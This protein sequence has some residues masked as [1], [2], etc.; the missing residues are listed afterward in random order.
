MCR[1]G[2]RRSNTL[3]SIF[4]SP[5]LPVTSSAHQIKFTILSDHAG[6]SATALHHAGFARKLE[7]F[8]GVETLFGSVTQLAILAIAPCVHIT[9]GVYVGSMLFA[10][11]EVFDRG[12]T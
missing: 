5:Q 4:S 6:M 11:R 2:P 12:L 9:L 1:R 8:R 7:L 10:A 3:C